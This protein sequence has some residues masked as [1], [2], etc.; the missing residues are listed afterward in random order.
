MCCLNCI[1]PNLIW[2]SF[3]NVITKKKKKHYTDVCVKN[4]NTLIN[5]QNSFIAYRKIFYEACVKVS[6]LKYENYLH[7]LSNENNKIVKTF[8]L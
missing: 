5:Y 2:L 3:G 1:I 6:S 8:K 4:K 7:I